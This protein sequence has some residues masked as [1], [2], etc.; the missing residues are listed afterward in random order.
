V[1]TFA[2]YWLIKFIPPFWL[3]ILATV[4][5]YTLG[6]IFTGRHS[7]TLKPAIDQKARDLGNTAADMAA[8]A[9]NQTR[10]KAQE[11]SSRASETASSASQ[12][13]V[14]RTKELGSQAMN[15][16]STATQNTASK[17]QELSSQTT[18][19]ASTASNNAAAT[20]QKIKDNSLDSMQYVTGQSTKLGQGSG[21]PSPI[22][23]QSTI[24]NA[25]TDG[26]DT[27]YAYDYKHAPPSAP[28]FAD[29]NVVK[30]THI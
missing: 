20:A 5:A 21:H 27:H 12:Y 30:E 26:I 13:T 29:K 9:T 8:T 15:T 16:A 22:G 28:G 11:L 19:M 1:S 24:N 17:A 14:D 18:D 23:T 7:D 2:A 4:L 6:P 25:A 3:A 10:D